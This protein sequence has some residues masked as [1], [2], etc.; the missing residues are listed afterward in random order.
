[1]AGNPRVL[2]GFPAIYSFEMR[3]QSSKVIT[4][5]LLLLQVL[6]MM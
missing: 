3:Y 5:R 6:P 1:M 2:Y 4:L